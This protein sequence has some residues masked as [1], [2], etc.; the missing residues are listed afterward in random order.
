MG[1]AQRVGG[2]RPVRLAGTVGLLLVLALLPAPARAQELNPDKR[3]DGLFVSV[4]TPITSD[5]C[6]RVKGLAGD[7]VRH[8]EVKKNG[9]TFKLVFDFT[10]N[11]SLDSSEFG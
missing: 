8:S 6:N 3:V 4:P 11:N 10:P 7:A 5:V 1:I 2:G 9:G